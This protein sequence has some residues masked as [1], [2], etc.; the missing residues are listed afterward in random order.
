MDKQTQPPATKTSKIKSIV[1]QIQENELYR[2]LHWEGTFEEYL[3]IVKKNPMVT[4]SAFERIY[5]MILSH[6]TEVYEE[7]REKI[8]HYK[9]FDD[10]IENGKDAVYGLD[11]Q[12]MKIVNLF[13][14]AANNYGTEKRV[15]L[16]HG[17][18]GSAKAPSCGY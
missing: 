16:L 3:D 14:S 15:F 12:L 1:G 2:E 5:D 17:P 10:P 13:K 7:Y 18:V 4:R 9:F 11:R 8:T 6:G